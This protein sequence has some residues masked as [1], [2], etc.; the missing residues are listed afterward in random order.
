L[1]VAI[2]PAA[3]AIAR[4][5][6]LCRGDPAPRRVATIFK[7]QP[8][9]ADPRPKAANADLHRMIARKPGLQLDQGDVGLFAT[10]ERTGPRHRP[11]ASAFARRPTCGPSRP[12]L[13]DA[14]QAP[15]KCTTR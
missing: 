6:R 13:C 8:K 9:M 11:Q 10:S 5:R 2:R 12:R 4:G 1:R 7:R 15:C 3:P 14:C